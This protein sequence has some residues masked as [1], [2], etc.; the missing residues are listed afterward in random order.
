MRYLSL[1]VLL[2]AACA[3]PAA[4]EAESSA[5][6]TATPEVSGAD[7]PASG[8][9]IA[10]PDALVAFDEPGGSYE[11][12]CTERG[13]TE[14]CRR[15]SGGAAAI[16][17]SEN[18]REVAS[19]PVARGAQA[20]EFAV[21]ASDL[22]RDGERDLIVATLTAVSN[23]LGVAYWTVDVLASGAEAPAY[24]FDA[25]DFSARGLGFDTHEGRDIVWATEWLS[26]DDPSGARGEGT[27]LVGRPFVLGSDRLTPEADLP[28][29]ARRLLGDFD[30]DP[31]IGPV[32][33]LSHEDA[34]DV[35]ADPAW[36][37]CSPRDQAVTITETRDDADTFGS[38]STLLTLADRDLRYGYSA[39]GDTDPLA[40]LGD[41]AS[42]RLFPADYRPAGL[43]T[44]L[45][46]GPLRLSEC[47]SGVRVLWL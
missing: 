33:W 9:P 18:G 8:E 13:P 39:S 20:G 26:A 24:S 27:Y 44:R 2:L 10:P 14:V 16:V 5:D 37:G 46:G 15:E 32:G 19:W 41:D 45:T 3:D 1:C 6:T 35:D 31:K 22:D 47:A 23:G 17:V 21:F 25:E 11:N 34:T 30:R 43:E 7:A 29:R 12:S 36:D 38:A 4:P 28:V 40:Y 42:G